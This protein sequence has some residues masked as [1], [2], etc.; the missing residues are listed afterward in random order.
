MT[1]LLARLHRLRRERGLHLAWLVDNGRR[2][3][4][5]EYHKQEAGRLDLEIVELEETLKRKEARGNG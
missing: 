1:A 2:G 5:A 3:A 4:L